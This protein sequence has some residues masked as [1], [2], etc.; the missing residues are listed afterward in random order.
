M[1]QQSGAH[2]WQG[3]FMYLYAAVHTYKVDLRSTWYFV[4][5]LAVLSFGLVDSEKQHVTAT[6]NSATGNQCKSHSFRPSC[7]GTNTINSIRFYLR[8]YSFVSFFTLRKPPVLPTLHAFPSELNFQS[9]IG[10]QL[11]STH[12]IKLYLWRVV[13]DPPTKNPAKMKDM[14][15]LRVSSNDCPADFF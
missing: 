9:I 3:A 7:E 14:D 5:V 1:T 12:L 8:Y 10:R 4:T 2:H 13:A 6:H 11:L 15:S